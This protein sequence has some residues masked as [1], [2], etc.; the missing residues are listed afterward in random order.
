MR[1]YSSPGRRS[2]SESGWVL[3]QAAA[4]VEDGGVVEDWGVAAIGSHW[5]FAISFAEFRGDGGVGGG[6][7][8]GTLGHGN[9]EEEVVRGSVRRRAP[10]AGGG[11]EIKL[12]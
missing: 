2:T 4:A 9:A 10:V 12:T 3:L 7:G 5:V 1:R 6:G 8:G 11:R